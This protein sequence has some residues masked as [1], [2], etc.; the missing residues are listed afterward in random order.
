MSASYRKDGGLGLHMAKPNLPQ[1]LA[2]NQLAAFWR[3]QHRR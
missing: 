3:L 2:V 1:L